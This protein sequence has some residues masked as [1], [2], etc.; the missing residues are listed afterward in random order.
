MSID[1]AAQRRHEEFVRQQHERSLANAAMQTNSAAAELIAERIA[2]KLAEQNDIIYQIGQKQ[3]RTSFVAYLSLV[4][5][6]VAAVGQ[7]FGPVWEWPVFKGI[8]G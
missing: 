3:G 1:N 8:F 2:A 5:G 7:L 6:G 4:I